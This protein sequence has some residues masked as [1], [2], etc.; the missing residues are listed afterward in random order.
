[1]FGLAGQHGW[2]VGELKYD[3]H[4]LESVFNRLAVVE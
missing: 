3:L 2:Q 4:T 1:V